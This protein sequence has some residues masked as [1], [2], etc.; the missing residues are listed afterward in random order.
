M[1]E[2]PAETP[3]QPSAAPARPFLYPSRIIVFTLLAIALVALGFDIAARLK[4]RSAFGKLQP[5]V[6]EEHPETSAEAALAEPCTPS[7]VLTLLGRTPDSEER[8]KEE[9]HQTYTWQ[10]V[11]NRYHIHAHYGGVTLAAED[12][13]DAEPLLLRVEQASNYIWNN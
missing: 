4:Q 12:P 6:D 8:G 1:S 5:Y 13:A 10:G 2:A 3:Q 7:Y 9:L 11:F